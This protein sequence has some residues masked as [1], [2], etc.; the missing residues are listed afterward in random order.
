ELL[1]ARGEH[2][3]LAPARETDAPSSRSRFLAEALEQ[4]LD[5]GWRTADEF[6]RH[7]PP[8]RVMEDLD[9]QP[10]ARAAMLR[11]LIGVAERT[12][13]RTPPDD[14]GRLLQNALDTG[15]CHAAGYAKAF[16]RASVSVHI[17]PAHV[18]SFV[19]GKQLFELNERRDK[20]RLP[21][22]R[23]LVAR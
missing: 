23:R 3:P 8:S 12:A 2:A 21:V 15:D 9:Q 7:F 5:S 20:T 11:F 22:A 14:A 16:H 13:L 17:D 18:W 10:T 6:A 1:R 4:A 19:A